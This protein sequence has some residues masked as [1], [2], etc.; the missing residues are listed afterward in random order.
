MAIISLLPVLATRIVQAA[1]TMSIHP[2]IMCGNPCQAAWA[3]V[4]SPNP[5]NTWNILA[6]AAGTGPT[7]IWAVGYNWD[8]TGQHVYPLVE[9]WNGRVWSIVPSPNVPAGE[10]K[11]LSVATISSTDAWAVGYQSAYGS[12]QYMSLME[13]WNGQQWSVV[14]SPNPGTFYNLLFGVAALASNDV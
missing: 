13:H 6:S 1:A 7:N 3:R 9:H 11:L 4:P 2:Q 12:G 10:G 5:S 14:S 8:N